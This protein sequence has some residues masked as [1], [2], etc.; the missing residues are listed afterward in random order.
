[1]R[2]GVEIWKEY[3]SCFAGRRTLL[4]EFMPDGKMETLKREAAALREI[5]T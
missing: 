5:V 2:E 4:L 3:L 1:L